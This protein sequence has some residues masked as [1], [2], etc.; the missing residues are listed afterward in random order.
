MAADKRLKKIWNGLTW[1][2]VY[3]PTSGDL[4]ILSDSTILDDK[5]QTIEGDIQDHVTDVTMHKTSGEQTKLDNLATNANSTYATKTELTTHEGDTTLH[6]TSGD[7]SKLANLDADANA[8][9]ATKAELA[10]KS[11]VYIYETYADMITDLTNFT[12]DEI[13]A[14]AIVK[15]ASGDLVN[16]GQGA[17][18]YILGD[19]GS[20]GVEWTYL[21][22]FT[23]GELHV[24]WDDIDDG[25][26]STPTQIDDAVSK[27]HTHANKS[28][29]DKLT[30]VAGDL[31]YD[32]NPIGIVYNK[33]Y[34]Q[35]QE[36]D[37][38]N[39]NDTWLAPI[40]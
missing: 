24:E 21:F 35:D 9:Y 17:A 29:I 14:M 27:V 38:P 23:S 16:E 39:V 26:S 12:T 7:I 30:D 11:K 3:H 5:I 13:G 32:G 4:V 34:Y 25:P 31:L 18:Q 36:P 20:S 37:D 19:D 33:T 10:G 28:V 15:D 22:H 2:E 40:E 1:V 8:T 6:K